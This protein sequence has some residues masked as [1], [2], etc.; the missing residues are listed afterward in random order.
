MLREVARRIVGIAEGV[1]KAAAF[2]GPLRVSFRMDKLS[3]SEN[4]GNARD[5]DLDPRGW[6]TSA[7]TRA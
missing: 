1:N 4:G 2:S 6:L 5:N 7:A 3:P